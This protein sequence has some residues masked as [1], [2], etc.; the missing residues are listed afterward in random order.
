M[1][2]VRPASID[3]WQNSPADGREAKP[4]AWRLVSIVLGLLLATHLVLLG[5]FRISSLDTW[6][7]LKQGELYVTTRSLPT[8]DPF[9]FT[10][11]G[12]EWIKYSWLSDVLFYLIYAAA[13]FPGLILLRLGLLFLLA[14][15]LYWLLR[16]CGLHPLAAVLLVFVASLALRFR[17]FI[18]P[19]ILSFLLLLTAMAILLRLQAGPRWAAY[20]LVPVQ[21]VW[22]N[23]HASFVFGIGLPGL[24]LLANL[25]PGDRLAPGW[26]HLRLDRTRIRHL[27]GAV[28]CLPLAALLNPQGFSML[29][30]PLR[31]NRMIRLTAFPEWRGVWGLPEMDPVWWEP[32]IIFVVVL[33]AFIAVSILLWAWENRFDPVGWGVV[34]SMGTYAVM[35]N[36]AIPYFILAVLPLLGLAI[37]RV[38][39]HLPA[40]VS[41]RPP[42]W[43][44]RVGILACLL[45]LTTSIVDQAFLTQRFAPGFGVAPHFF[46][47]GAAAFLERSHVDGRV[48][49]S[50]QFGGYLMWRR[51][52]ANTIFIDGR[53]DA[54]LFGEETL[55]AYFSAY[56]SPAALERVTAAYGIEILALAATPEDRMEHIDR[57]PVWARVYWD[58][59]AEVYVRR[60]GRFANLIAEHEYR[61][62]RSEANLAYLAAYRRDAD[63]W[64]Q[65]LAELRRAVADNPENELAWQG[66]AQEYGAAGPSALEQRLEALSRAIAVLAGNP[67]TGRLH[68]EQADALLQLGRV[69]EA[70]GAAQ[71]ALRLDGDL[72][73]PRYVLAAV[74]ERRGVWAE[75]RDQ[76][77]S[78]L[79]AL[80]P[81]DPEAGS[82]RRRLEAAE[83]RVRGERTR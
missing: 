35:R 63:T 68:A 43:L 4:R 12:R 14:F 36:R 39:R 59:V 73:L 40:E 34:L 62:T 67:A 28:V 41:G 38:A 33:F 42:Q 16:G 3:P 70:K 54:V 26:D 2:A 69:D 30:F 31:Q 22:T 57:N 71:T 58:P 83:R 5:F 81:D 56:R 74:A 9:A 80:P 51:W 13:G 25:L 29:L 20:A 18:R 49:N 65:A 46:P 19:E 64:A 24:V 8:E 48:F 72:L 66:L 52:P 55:E 17:L 44:A 79:T 23:V 50:Y 11:Q 61:L 77:C 37:L 6:F 75:A 7:H 1:D 76:L 47:E 15:V 32:V 82:V 27:A 60:G 53:Y 21:I 78:I 10:T 45:V